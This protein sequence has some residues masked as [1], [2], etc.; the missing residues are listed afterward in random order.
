MEYLSENSLQ[1]AVYHREKN[2][3]TFDKYVMIQKELHI[4]LENLE[5]HGYKIIDDHLKVQLLLAG[6]KYGSLKSVKSTILASAPYRQDY[7][8]NVIIYK[9]YI[10]Q[11]Q[12]TN[13]EF[14]ISGYGNGAG[15][16]SGKGIF[17]GNI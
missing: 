4:I 15:E 2:N 13:V 6:I 5:Q 3:N 16:S 9:D 14:N 10:K 7:D 1:N 12:N 17:T 8:A 11:A